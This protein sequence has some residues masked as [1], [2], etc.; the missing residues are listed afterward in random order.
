MRST[1]RQ[2]E[3][4]SNYSVPPVFEV[5]EDARFGPIEIGGKARWCPNFLYFFVISKEIV[6]EQGFHSVVDLTIGQRVEI[7]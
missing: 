5:D 1:I 3:K 2:E 6:W 4:T 7:T